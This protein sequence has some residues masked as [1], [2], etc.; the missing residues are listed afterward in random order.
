MSEFGIVALS[1][2]IGAFA[3]TLLLTSIGLILLFFRAQKLL[4]AHASQLA[5]ATTDL[6]TL[7]T[8][9]QADLI[10]RVAEINGEDLKEA[11]KKIDVSV[12]ALIR[13]VKD[14]QQA[15]L[16]MGEIYKKMFSN[17]EV[18]TTSLPADAYAEPDSE[19]ARF[20]SQSD[21]AKRDAGT[22]ED[23]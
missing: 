18:A 23:M 19:G 15:C 16:V 11:A 22:L 13:A 20:I 2:L 1:I 5:S 12:R 17:T 4:T 14:N 9:V 8:T 6:H 10:K 3:L 7:V 21:A